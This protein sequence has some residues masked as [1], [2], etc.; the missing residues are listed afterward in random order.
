MG[1]TCALTGAAFARRAKFGDDSNDENESDVPE[2]TI[3]VAIQ[4][5]LEHAAG[6]HGKVWIEG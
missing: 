6:D 3:A 4:P 5:W 1:G 2:W